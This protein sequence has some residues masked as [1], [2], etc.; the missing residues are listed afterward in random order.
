MHLHRFREKKKTDEELRN[1]KVD[2]SRVAEWEA[3]H[4]TIT[5]QFRRFD[6]QQ[7]A[8]ALY[9]LDQ[10][11]HLFYPENP[12]SLCQRHAP[13][14]QTLTPEQ[15]PF[16]P[17]DPD[18]NALV[19]EIESSYAKAQ[20]EFCATLAKG[21]TNSSL[22]LM[23]TSKVHPDA[24]AWKRQEKDRLA[25]LHS[26]LP[27][28]E[29]AA[30]VL[31]ELKSFQRQYSSRLAHIRDRLNLA[32]Q[33]MGALNRHEERHGHV[34]AKAA[35][36]D[37][38]TRSRASGLKRLVKRSSMCPYCGRPLGSDAHLDHI[39]PV[40]RGGL[41]IVENLVWCCSTCNTAKADRGLMQFLEMR[42][43]AGDAV[44]SRLLQMGKHV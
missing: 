14:L 44:I 20:R 5:D 23:F 33:K 24:V 7:M 9:E 11:R 37:K 1:L 42:G 25:Q 15:L 22:A 18:V 6:L 13:T 27:A 38:L 41:S 39:Y 21:V 12:Y 26:R 36:A 2:L 8:A 28:V 32:S 3:E 31:R 30:T 35:A 10:V 16:L 40:A 29:R 34:F 17:V 43:I 4:K 19:A